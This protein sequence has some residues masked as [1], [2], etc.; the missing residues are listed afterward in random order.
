MITK[1]CKVC[2]SEFQ[3]KAHR[4]DTARYC[5]RK[6]QDDARRLSVIVGSQKWCNKGQHF[7]SLSDFSLNRSKRDGLASICKRC[8]SKCTR[9]S[10]AKNA[11]KRKA[12][13]RLYYKQHAADG[14]AKRKLYLQRNPEKAKT[15]QRRSYY[16]D[17]QRTRELHNNYMREYKANNLDKLRKKQVKGRHARRARDINAAGNFTAEQWLAKCELHG[18]RC[19]LCRAELTPQTVQVE[20][21]KPLSRGGSNWI[22]NIAPACAFC[23]ASKG[24]K[25]ESEY[26]ALQS[27]IYI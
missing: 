3:V 10:Q 19:Y 15:Y 12:Y 20:H 7:V 26:R 18:W 23:N 22:A 17:V 21:R 14:L 16:K 5:S 13:T 8:S 24:T 25:T 2:N 11:E 4:R 6:C 1:V 27:N 9:V